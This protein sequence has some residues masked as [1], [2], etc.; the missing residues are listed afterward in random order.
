M[1][2]GRGRLLAVLDIGVIYTTVRFAPQDWEH[3]SKFVGRNIS[4]ILGLMILL[5]CWG[6]RMY[7]LP[8]VPG[9]VMFMYSY[10]MLFGFSHYRAEHLSIFPFSVTGRE[11]LVVEYLPMNWP[12]FEAAMTTNLPENSGIYHLVPLGARHGEWR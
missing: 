2:P 12:N 10:V 1:P 7:L 9:C 8:E 3:T 4:W 11:Y 6:H 5:S